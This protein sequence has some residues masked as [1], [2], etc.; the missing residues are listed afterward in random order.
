[1]ELLLASGSL[2]VL[3]ALALVMVVIF[4]RG[5]RH[6]AFFSKSSFAS[7]HARRVGHRPLRRHRVLRVPRLKTVIEEDEG[8]V[9]LAEGVV[10]FTEAPAKF[11][12][13][14]S[15][16]G[17]HLCLNGMPDTDDEAGVSYEDTIDATAVFSR[18]APTASVHLVSVHASTAC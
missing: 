3:I 14:Q 15:D 2:V 18:S 5:Q 13:T 10:V 16:D 7:P 4:R 1:M 6:Q 11:P 9:L 17:G 8:D 12:L